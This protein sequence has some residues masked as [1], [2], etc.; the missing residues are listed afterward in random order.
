MNLVIDIGGT[1][2]RIN[3]DNY[4]LKIKH[5][6]NCKKDLFELIEKEIEICMEKNKMNINKLIIALP[7]IVKNYKL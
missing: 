4:C 6:M 2:F 1:H 7:G 5:N 3:Y